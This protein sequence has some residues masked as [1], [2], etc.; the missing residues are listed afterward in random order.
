[1]KYEIELRRSFSQWGR[2]AIEA[3]NDGH[4][5]A[6]ACGLK[7][8]DIAVWKTPDEFLDIVS[9]TECDGEGRCG[10]QD[11]PYRLPPT[12]REALGAVIEYLYDDEAEDYQT[13]TKSD[14]EGHIFESVSTLNRWLRGPERDR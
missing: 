9:V 6:V 11:S 1:M 13:L 4:A 12:I 10:D 7:A 2:T 8:S 5:H 14:Q 3:V